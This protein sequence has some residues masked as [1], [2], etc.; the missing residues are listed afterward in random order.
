MTVKSVER[1]A[2]RVEIEW[3]SPC[4]VDSRRVIGWVLADHTRMGLIQDALEMAAKRHTDR[5]AW[6]TRACA[7]Q[8]VP[9][10]IERE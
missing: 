5:R 10:R 3:P 1:A 6:P 7:I 2:V 9:A 8:G 4:L